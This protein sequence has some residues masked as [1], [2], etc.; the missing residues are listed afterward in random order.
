MRFMNQRGEEIHLADNLT[1]RELTDMGM[2]VSLTEVTDL[3][4]QIWIAEPEVVEED[5]A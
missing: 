1:L 4:H 5:Q 2:D 3:E